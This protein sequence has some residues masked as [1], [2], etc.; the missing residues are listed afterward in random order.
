MRDI[1]Y[2]AG[3]YLA[4]HRWKTAIL[5]TMI[6][7]LVY[8]PLGLN[9]L[10]HQSSRQLTA[11]AA[12]TPL[13]VGAKGSPLELVLRSLYFESDVPS[14][15]TYSQST[16]V[17]KSALAR[18]I[19]LHA[20]YRTRHG[21]IVGTSL[22]YFEF[23]RLRFEQGRYFGMLGECVMGARAASRAGINVG[24][25]VMSIPETVF[26]LA[27]VYPLKMK[28]VGVL[29]PSGTP[30]DNAV[31]V[32]IK[33]A[34]VIA[35]LAHGHDDLSQ[36]AA[37]SG[38]LRQEEDKIIANASVR[39][40]NEITADNVSSFHF[41]GQRADFPVTAVIVLPTD[42]KSQT[43][44]LGRYLGAD[45]LVQIVAPSEVMDELLQTV[46]TVRRYVLIAVGVIATATLASLA[47]VFLLSLQ[48][49]RGEMDTII[50][51]GGSRR[52]IA[53]LV[54]TE[55]CGVLAAGCLLAVL[56]AVATAWTAESATR[57]LVQLT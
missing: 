4:Y 42:H 35:G 54:A 17:L 30:D 24:D 37:R 32:D 33:T 38:V 23:R 18:A 6:T 12:A 46:L 1:L 15:T 39:Q 16:R 9:V 5:V 47:L 57:L 31:F 25:S 56:L 11:R 27:G 29:Q 43:L 45:E 8:L 48:L 28:V 50:K 26:D 3:R 2:L 21:P 40:Y 55:V 22:A 51:I 13:V 52:R 49:R 14:D 19:P 44:L 53:A 36:P 34:W 10:V 41:H 20:R 7:L